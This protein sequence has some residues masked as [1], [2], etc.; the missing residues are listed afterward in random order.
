MSQCMKPVIA[1]TGGTVAV[2]VN[3]S[4][5]QRAAL[6]SEALLLLIRDFGGVPLIVPDRLPID[7]AIKLLGHAHGLILPPGRDLDS[8]MYGEASAVKYGGVEGLGVKWHRPDFVGPDPHRDAL[9]LEL[10]KVARARRLPILGI[11]RGMQLIN[12]ACSGTLQQE[13]DE[14]KV[15]HFL[16]E[17]GWIPYH[18]IS[19]RNGSLLRAILGVDSVV[20]SSVH[21]QGVARLGD[22]LIACAHAADGVVEALESAASEDFIFGVQAHIEK[23]RLNFAEFDPLIAAFIA[24]SGHVCRESRV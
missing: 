8:S 22:G 11:C 4:R 2:S 6:V 24:A 23:T 18:P 14:V 19:V 1:I 3:A 12:V 7:D 16:E 9:E 17:D 21:H 20:V 5:M 10:F 13:L 15:S